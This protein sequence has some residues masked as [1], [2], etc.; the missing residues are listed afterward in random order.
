[1]V[2][3][4]TQGHAAEQ[5]AE[6]AFSPGAAMRT[7]EKSHAEVTGE[8]G[9]LS[10]NRVLHTDPIILSLTC[11]VKGYFKDSRCTDLVEMTVEAVMD[12]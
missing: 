2:D 11:G 8:V 10:K 1:M 5:R 6:E 7:V 9:P 3:D 4:F 12:N